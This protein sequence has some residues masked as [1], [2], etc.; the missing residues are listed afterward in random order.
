MDQL[1]LIHEDIYDALRDCIKA[2]GGNKEVGHIFWPEKPIEKAGEQLADC[3]NRARPQK[4]D[5]EQTLYILKE[6]RKVGCHIGMFF[7]TRVCDYR[8]PEPIEPLDEMAELQKA[9]IQSVAE[10]RRLLERM[11]RM[12]SLQASDKIRSA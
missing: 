9:F 12:Q 3:L 1:N 7:I 5:P 2:L 4:L 8:Q 10:N 11:E 6:A